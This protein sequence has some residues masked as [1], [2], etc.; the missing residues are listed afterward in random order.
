MQIIVTDRF[1]I[2]AGIQIQIAYVVISIH[3]PSRPSANVP[4]QANL[5]DVLVLSFHD[6]DPAV[7]A[8]EEGPPDVQEMTSEQAVKVWD[9]VD[10]YRSEV[11][12][13]V[14]HCEGGFSRSPAVAAAIAEGLGLDHRRF[15]RNYMPNQHVYHTMLDAFDARQ[16]KQG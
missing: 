10:R 12:A 13:I 2:E 1:G 11:E 8:T 3:D 5:R 15:L 7:Y 16:E 14:V 9:F 6:A 4:R